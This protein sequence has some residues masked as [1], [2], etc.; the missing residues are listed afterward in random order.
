VVEA[1]PHDCNF[2]IKEKEG[3]KVRC[4]PSRDKTA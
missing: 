4:T 1:L 2:Q 3:L